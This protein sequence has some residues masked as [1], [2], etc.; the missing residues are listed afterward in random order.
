[1]LGVWLTILFAL[2]VFSIFDGD[3]GEDIVY[4]LFVTIVTVTTAFALG[5]YF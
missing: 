3:S 1:M 4:R 2:N 5:D